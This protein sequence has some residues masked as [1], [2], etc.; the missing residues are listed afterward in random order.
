MKKAAVALIVLA[1]VLFPT[2]ASAGLWSASVPF[3]NQ[4]ASSP[5]T[6]GGYPV[7]PGQTAPDPGTCRPGDYDANRSES[8]IAVQPGT[9]DLVGTSKAFFE[10]FS[11]FYDFHLGSYTIPGGTPA[12]NNIVQGYE[13]VSTG[14]QA[15]PPSWMNNTDPNVDFDTKGRAYQVTLPFNPWWTNHLH[16]DA[17]IGIVYSDDLGRTWV[18]GNGGAY[19]DHVP[20]QSSKTFGGVEDKQ[21]VA[22]NHIPDN[23]YQ[24]HVYAAWAVFNGAAIEVR[25]AISRDRGQSF[26][27]AVILSAPAQVGPAVTYAYPSVD[28]AGNVYVS[29]VSFPPSGKSSVIYVTRSSDDGRSWSAFSPVTT[30]GTLAGCCLPNTTFRDGIVES[31]AASPTYPGHL[32]LT[33]EDWDGQQFDVKLTQSTDGGATWTVPVVVNDNVDLTATDQFQPSVAA[34]PDGAVAVA[35]YDR[36]AACP[37]DPSVLLADVG[38]QNFCIDTSLQA[39]KDSGAGAVPVGGNVR[40]SESTWDPE[41]PGQTID[42]IDQMACAAHRDPCTTNA[43]IGDY[44]GLAISGNNIYALMVSTH[45]PSDVTGDGGK[46][47]YYQQ[48]VLATVSRADIGTGY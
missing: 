28:A 25:I 18:K 22:V 12:G 40:I 10:E 21:W 23:P 27:K 39:Y 9:E 47:V 4:V 1:A 35:F 41:Q 46:T 36:R 17:A 19:L 48:Q 45:Y 30:V 15:M 34:G 8:W 37:S 31:F 16:P 24:D 3:T 44:F 6:A 26:S 7:P 20:N 33:Y 11:T 32:Y 14:T 38:R 13:C 43:F 2:P 29:V 42:G 5:F